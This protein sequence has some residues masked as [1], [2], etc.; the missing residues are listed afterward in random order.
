VK[1]FSGFFDEKKIDQL[2]ASLPDK[3]FGWFL[4]RVCFIG[5]FREK[6]NTLL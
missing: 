1:F 5:T 3:S 2:G 4:N 6:K